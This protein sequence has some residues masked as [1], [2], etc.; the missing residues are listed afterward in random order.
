[1][2]VQLLVKGSFGKIRGGKE[3]V[4]LV[5]WRIPDEWF[6]CVCINRRYS[7][8][9]RKGINV[10]VQPLRKRQ[11]HQ[12]VLFGSPWDPLHHYYLSN[13]GPQ[14]QGTLWRHLREIQILPEEAGVR[15]DSLCSPRERGHPVRER[16]SQ[17]YDREDP[18]PEKLEE[19]QEHSGQGSLHSHQ[20]LRHRTRNSQKQRSQ[21]HNHRRGRLIFSHHII[22]TA[23]SLNHQD[24]TFPMVIFGLPQ[25]FS[26]LQCKQA[27]L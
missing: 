13:L 16:T 17:R 6:I 20:V 23:S 22:S 26:D 24:H 12:E 15:Q 9:I 14:I 2:N 5:G 21:G 18:Y 8:I 27:T 11:P 10:R 3:G 7:N 1:M 25:N 19:E 4:E